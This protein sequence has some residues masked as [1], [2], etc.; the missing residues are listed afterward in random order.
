MTWLY[1]AAIVL[2]AVGTVITRRTDRAGLGVTA[3][4][5]GLA[6][7]WIAVYSTPA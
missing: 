1:L 5:A 6:V 7:A 4:L 2:C 3:Y